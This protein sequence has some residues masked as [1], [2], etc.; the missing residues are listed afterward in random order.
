MINCF[1]ILACLY[2]ICFFYFL[3]EN[4]PGLLNVWAGISAEEKHSE[5]LEVCPSSQAFFLLVGKTT[6]LKRILPPT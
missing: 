2:E 5:A 3:F 4:K 6:C 1:Q